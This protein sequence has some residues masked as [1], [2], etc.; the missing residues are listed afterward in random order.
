MVPKGSKRCFYTLPNHDFLGC[1]EV[2]IGFVPSGMYDPGPRLDEDVD[3]AAETADMP[4]SFLQSE[5]ALMGQSS[6]TACGGRWI[7]TYKH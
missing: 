1:L 6:A 5:E 2:I 7:I 3:P 4:A